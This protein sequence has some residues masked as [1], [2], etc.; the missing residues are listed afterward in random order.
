MDKAILG[1]DSAIPCGLIINELISNSLKYAFPNGNPGK[2]T[3]SLRTNGPQAALQI[4]DDGI[5]FPENLDFRNTTSL[6]MQLVVSLV[7]QINGDIQLC[8]GPGTLWTITFPI[9]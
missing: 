3:V 7:Q 1:L 5:G 8:T 2:I 6:G 4:M 9:L